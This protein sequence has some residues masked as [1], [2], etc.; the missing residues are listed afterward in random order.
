M[1][2]SIMIP[3]TNV[4]FASEESQIDFGP[5]PAASESDEI[6]DVKGVIRRLSSKSSLCEFDDLHESD[7]RRDYQT[8]IDCL[9]QCESMIKDLQDQL[10][11]KDERIESL[12]DKIMHMSLQLAS[13]MAREDHLQHKMKTRASFAD[14]ATN[15]S[16]F[17]TAASFETGSTPPL[18]DSGSVRFSMNFG[19]LLF[20]LRN[21]VGG[22]NE[23]KLVEEAQ[24]KPA[25]D[26]IE[27]DEKT[28]P[29]DET[30][31]MSKLGLFVRNN[32]NLKERRS[33]VDSMQMELPKA[34]DAMEEEKKEGQQ[35]QLNIVGNRR[36]PARKRME[37]RQSSRSFLEATGVVF[38]STSFD[39]LAKGCLVKSA[40]KDL[41]NEEWP[42]FG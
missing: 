37:R 15:V 22:R 33:S 17:T 6:N 39:V 10:L 5:N 8:A 2:E 18:D 27:N 24:E 30:C 11:A 38:P 41:G 3:F 7:L 12:E 16:S 29:V 25:A 4:D 14:Q 20:G 23:P 31:I 35:D 28:V 34:P 26:S 32:C 40:E 21:E 13:S 9:I 1:N 36:R 19:Q 42:K